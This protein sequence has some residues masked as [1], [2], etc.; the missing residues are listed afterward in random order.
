M[1]VM[2]WTSVELGKLLEY[3]GFNQTFLVIPS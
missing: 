3:E 2:M 1:I